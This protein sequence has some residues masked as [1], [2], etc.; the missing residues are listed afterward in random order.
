MPDKDK[1]PDFSQHVV[2][3]PYEEGVYGDGQD[4]RPLRTFAITNWL[5]DDIHTKWLGKDIVL[6][7]GEMRECG[8][9]EAY[10]FMKVIVDKYIFDEA[11]KIKEPKEREKMEMN[12][13]SPLYRKPLEEKTIQPIKDGEESPVMRKMREE[14][15]KKVRAEMAP[16]SAAGVTSSQARGEFED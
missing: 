2:D 10:H 15:E 4:G 7:T 14:I 13:L 3:T 6:K 8:H 9:A 12:I 1:K 11:A 5:T 16:N